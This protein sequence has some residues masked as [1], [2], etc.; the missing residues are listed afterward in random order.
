MHVNKYVMPAVVILAM[1]G[2]IAIAQLSG[3]WVTSGKAMVDPGNLT[4][5][6]IKG[7]MTWQDISQGTGIS[8]ETLYRLLD[9][10]ADIPITAAMKDMEGLVEGFETSLVRER[11]AA[12]LAGEEAAGDAA[13]AA[14][15]AGPASG[16]ASSAPEV[17]ESPAALPVP[18]PTHD[19][20]YQPAASQR[21]PAATDHVP[22][23]DGSGA[24]PTPLPPGQTL[25][26]SEI[27]GRHT[28]AEVAAQC[29][30][31]LEQIYAALDLPADLDPDTQ[32]KDL[33]ASRQLEVQAVRDAVAGLQAASR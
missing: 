11:L 4:P 9:V 27:K 33:A 6:D 10:P 7:W 24:G 26:A 14:E 13:T 2:T 8:P 29:A 1:L 31:P 22:A 23:G 32:L 19:A 5:Q 12:Y 3:N 15:L 21:D 17:T 18:A 20:E 25:P 16:P 28:L 30:V